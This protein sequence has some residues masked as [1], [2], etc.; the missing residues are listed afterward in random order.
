MLAMG[1]I[2]VVLALSMIGVVVFSCSVIVAPSLFDRRYAVIN[3]PSKDYS[4]S[5]GKSPFQFFIKNL[6]DK[7]S[8]K[9]GR[10]GLSLSKNEICKFEWA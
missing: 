1:G 3:N 4:R 2:A 5:V 6:K 7:K 9:T 8:T 10:Q